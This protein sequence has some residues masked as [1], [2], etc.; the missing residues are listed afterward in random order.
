[1]ASGE[2]VYARV[3][4]LVDEWGRDTVGARG[5]RSIGAVVGGTHPEQGAGCA[6]AWPGVPFLI[7]GYGA[8]GATA[9]DLAALFD[10]DGHGGG[11]QFGP[12]HPLRVPE[13]ARAPL[14]GC[15]PRRGGGHEG[16]PVAAAGRG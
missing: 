8:Q 11:G 15:R 10:A 13:G 16:R 3:A 14:A 7:P 4:D 2:P 9:G 12:G 6:S 5:Y 1:M